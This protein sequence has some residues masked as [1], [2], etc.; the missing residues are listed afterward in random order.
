MVIGAALAFVLSA[1]GGVSARTI[2]SRYA[3]DWSRD[4]YSGMY[5][6]LTTRSRRAISFRR[7][8]SDYRGALATATASALEAGRV[9][10]AGTH[11]VPVHFTVLTHLFG[12]LHETLQ[13]PIANGPSGPRVEFSGVLLFPGLRAGEQLSRR[14]SLG[15]RGTILADDGTPLAEGPSRTSPLPGVASEIVGTLG[16]I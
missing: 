3:R 1:G 6:L 2:A 13:V 9:G 14:S 8:E 15:R 4:E 11:S 16:P 12:R 10:D 5:G 7:F